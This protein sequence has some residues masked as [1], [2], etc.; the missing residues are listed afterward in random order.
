MS[1]TYR[2]QLLLLKGVLSEEPEETQKAVQDAHAIIE[3]TYNT[4]EDKD[5]ADA[6]FTL[7]VMEMIVKAEEAGEI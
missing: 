2:A 4:M 7:F 5:I 1:S 3:E 6:A